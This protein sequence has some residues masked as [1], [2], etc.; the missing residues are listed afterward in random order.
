M[1][2]PERPRKGVWDHILSR[3]QWIVLACLAIV[4]ALAWWWLAGM[5]EHATDAQMSGMA[6]MDMPGMDMSGMV[7]PAEPQFVPTALMWFIM[8][9]AMML[10]STAPMILL[11]QRF[12]HATRR[13]G[14]ALMPTA[15]FALLYLV[16]WAGFSALASIAQIALSRAGLVDAVSMAVGSRNVAGELLIAAAIYQLTPAKRACLDNCRSPISFLQREWG[17]GRAN[18]VRLGLKHGVYCVGCCWLLMS[19]LFVGG[20]MNLAWVAVLALI[21]LIEKVAPAPDVS[22]WAIA[23][24]ALG[25]GMYLLLS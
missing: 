21:V 3:D 22:R 13:A 17:P 4:C 10:P 6:G 7:M 11:Y 15:L 20:V 1:E 23:I 12:A 19:L 16:V 25:G 24:A 18:A 2:Q 8:M 14:G 9:V 5:Q